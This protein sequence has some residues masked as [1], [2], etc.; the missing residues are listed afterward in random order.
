MFIIK[1]GL[2]IFEKKKFKILN[3]TNDICQINSVIHT[4]SV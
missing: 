3:E 4:V 1:K 2:K